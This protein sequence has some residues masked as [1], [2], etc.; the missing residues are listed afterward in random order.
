MCVRAVE[1][2]QLCDVLREL[3]PGG[4]LSCVLVHCEIGHISELVQTI[5]FSRFPRQMF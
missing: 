4:L 3:R 1:G 2:H 5:S